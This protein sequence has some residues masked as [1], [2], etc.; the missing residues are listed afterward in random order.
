MSLAAESCRSR[1][2]SVHLLKPYLQWGKGCKSSNFVSRR[3]RRCAR[4]CHWTVR[5]VWCPFMGLERCIEFGL[6]KA[7]HPSI[8]RSVFRDR[9]FKLNR[10]HSEE[11]TIVQHRLWSWATLKLGI[12]RIETKKLWHRDDSHRWRWRTSFRIHSWLDWK[13][14]PSL[15]NLCSEVGD[16]R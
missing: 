6:P 8:V 7:V 14:V 2:E 10:L 12:G 3:L 11:K 16:K 1:A 5:F 4:W 9:A 15:Q 13:T